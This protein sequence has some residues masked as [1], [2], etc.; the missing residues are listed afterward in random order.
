M[1]TSAG[2]VASLD[3]V[4][5]GLETSAL[6][7]AALRQL[8]GTGG[9]EEYRENPVLKPGLPGSWD[10]GALGS[11][12]IVKVDKLY[13]LY[14]EAWGV[15]GDSAADYST[16]QI[17]HAV[18]LDGIHWAKD[19]ANPVLP[20]G[21]PS[22]WDRDGTWD[23]FVIYEDGLF[24]LWYG[25]GM[26]A[27]CDWGY[28][29]SEDGRT[30]IKKGRISRLGNVED[31]H[32]VYDPV[33][34]RY[35]MYYWD[36]RQE[37]KG[38]FRATGSDEKGFDFAG[39]TPLTIAGESPGMYKFSHVIVEHGVWY[40]FYS[41]FLRPNCPAGT[42]RLAT[43]PDGVQWTSVNKRLVAGHDG[44]LV[45]ADEGVYLLYYGPQ[46]YFDA[47][48]CDIRVAVYA[49]KLDELTEQRKK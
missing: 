20:K 27:H 28:A 24:K 11:M 33:S 26:D 32:V 22:D 29:E 15:R 45:Q 8:G 18:S 37:P 23:P 5:R 38:L 36:R 34:N 44:E 47:K 16:L 46:G 4:I 12:T 6:D 42:V 41:D 1:S 43:S 49:G 21:G 7:R 9:F 25:G 2:E 31:D 48:N 30:F 35:H 10:A 14:Y 13:H 40:M 17:G 39:A 3:D 19:P